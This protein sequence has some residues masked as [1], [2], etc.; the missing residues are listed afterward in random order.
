VPALL[1]CTSPG[2]GVATAGGAA[3]GAAAGT[4][5]GGVPA[6]S[7]VAEALPG[8]APFIA[9]VSESA[10]S[11]MLTEPLACKDD[12]GVGMSQVYCGAEVGRATSMTREQWINMVKLAA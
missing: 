10:R 3:A 11:M 12:S 4:A 5:A 6:V 8:A 1:S 7:C 9:V 2:P